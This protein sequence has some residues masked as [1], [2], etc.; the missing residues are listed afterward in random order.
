MSGFIVVSVVA[1]AI[2][3][4]SDRAHV[5]GRGEGVRRLWVRMTFAVLRRSVF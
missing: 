1:R 3:P 5:L 4:G 2:A